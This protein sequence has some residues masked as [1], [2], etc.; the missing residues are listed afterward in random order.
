MTQA[1]IFPC[2]APRTVP[3]AE[4]LAEK[5]PAFSP[6][7]DVYVIIRPQELFSR[8]WPTLDV[9]KEKAA[10]LIG[11]DDQFIYIIHMRTQ[12]IFALEQKEKK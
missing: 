2:P 12:N 4:L 7:A 8:C 11:A 6:E 5:A 1:T 10:K 3:L 9:A